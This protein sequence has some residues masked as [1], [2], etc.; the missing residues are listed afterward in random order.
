M[1]TH[2]EPDP[3]CQKE[4]ERKYWKKD[5]VCPLLLHHAKWGIN[6]IGHC[7]PEHCQKYAIYQKKLPTISCSELN[8]GQKSS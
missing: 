6:E 8:F 5:V 7:R 2:G 1:H 4:R 3:V